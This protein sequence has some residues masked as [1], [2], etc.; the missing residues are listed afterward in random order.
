[1]NESMTNKIRKIYS[2][3]HGKLLRLT[4]TNKVIRSPKFASSLPSQSTFL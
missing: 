4:R 1:M 2:F 3:A